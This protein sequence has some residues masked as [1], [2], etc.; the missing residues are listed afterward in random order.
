MRW[1]GRRRQCLFA[2]WRRLLARMAA[3]AVHLVP[4]A[5][6]VH[7]GGGRRGFREN[8]TNRR[9]GRVEVLFA[10]YASTVDLTMDD[11][12]SICAFVHEERL[13]HRIRSWSIKVD[14]NTCELISSRN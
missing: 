8:D 3:A 6:P 1:R 9:T 13:V 14:K 12:H 11:L 7:L 10:I 4:P 5:A 2:G